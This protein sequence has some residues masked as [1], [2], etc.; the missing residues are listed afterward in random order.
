MSETAATGLGGII[1]PPSPV[2]NLSAS[3]TFRLGARAEAMTAIESTSSP[4]RA[5]GRRPKES[6]SGLANTRETAQAPKVAVASCPTTET[7]APN[8]AAMSTSRGGS[9]R[10]AF[11]V[12][13]TANRSTLRNQ[14]LFTSPLSA[15]AV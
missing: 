5:T 9:I 1:P 4:A 13:R 3:S 8:S 6:D 7:D 11:I 10:T 14:A 12:T 2:N 15:C